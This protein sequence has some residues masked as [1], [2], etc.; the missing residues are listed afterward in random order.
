MED[1]RLVVVTHEAATLSS[2]RSFL[3]TSVSI[4]TTSSYP[5]TLMRSA[6]PVLGAIS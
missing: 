2:G 4:S 3:K 5:Y 1:A 6:S